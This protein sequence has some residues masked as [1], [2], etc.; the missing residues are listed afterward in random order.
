MTV[1]FKKK[2]QHVQAEANLF[3]YYNVYYNLLLQL[4]K[5]MYRKL[6]LANDYVAVPFWCL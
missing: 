1:L 2:P 6:I 3:H 4:I 5:V